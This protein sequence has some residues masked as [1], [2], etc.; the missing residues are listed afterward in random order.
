VKN[1][2][3]VINM[4]KILW[5][6]GFA[7]IVTI[8]FV[9]ASPFFTVAN[10]KTGIIEQD[11][12]KLSDNIDFPIFRRNLKNQFNRAMMNNVGEELR[13]NPLAAIAAGFATKMADR[14]V[15]SFVTPNGLARLMEGKK[16]FISRSRRNSTANANPPKRDDLFRNARYS[17]DSLNRFSVWVPTETGDEIRFILQR[18]GFSWK[19]VDLG[20]VQK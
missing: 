6:I 20:V 5:I 15:D 8:G 16:P 11:S 4:K 13:D 17:Y 9:A 12:E 18:D 10:I 3:Q 2:W 1:Y 19:L 14:V 7:I